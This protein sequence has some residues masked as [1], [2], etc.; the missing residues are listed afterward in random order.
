M[1]RGGVAAARR[2][3]LAAAPQRADALG[4]GTPPG[5]RA[6]GALRRAPCRTATVPLP[7]WPCRLPPR[8]APCLPLCRNAAAALGLRRRSGRT[9]APGRWPVALPAR[10]SRRHRRSRSS[11][12]LERAYQGEGGGPKGTGP[13][14]S[15]EL[16]WPFEVGPIGL[17]V[18]PMGLVETEREA[19][20]NEFWAKIP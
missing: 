13:L 8:P 1:P 4:A 18:W 19:T 16:L 6:P 2:P 3:P 20:G 14:G 12:R 7:A 17:I 10:S 5:R 15:K 11:R 9:S